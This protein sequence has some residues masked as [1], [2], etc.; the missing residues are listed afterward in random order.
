MPTPRGG[1]AG[2]VFD[3]LFVVAGGEQPTATH[4]EVEAFDPETRQWLSLP[5]LPTP[6]H[7]LAAVV[8]GDTLYVIGGGKRPGLS[9]S[10]S[11][12]ALRVTQG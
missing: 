4:S 6:R 5:R 11:N 2:T 8:L 12:E 3:G 1:I 9:V 10:G 7:G